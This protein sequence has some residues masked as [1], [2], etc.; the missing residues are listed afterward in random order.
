[1]DQRALFFLMDHPLLLLPC[2][3]LV[4]CPK[5]W[6]QIDDS[7]LYSN[8]IPFILSSQ[9]GSR[10]EKIKFLY[11][12][13]LFHIVEMVTKVGCFSLFSLFLLPYFFVSFPP[14]FFCSL[15][16]ILKTWFVTMAFFSSVCCSSDMGETY[17]LMMYHVVEF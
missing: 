7:C 4:S 16:F 9:L 5:S 1:M 6:S 12:Y 11:F 15:P 14:L 8:W 2:V 3:C 13:Y 10:W 17:G